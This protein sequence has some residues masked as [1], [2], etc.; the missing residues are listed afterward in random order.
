VRAY[1]SEVSLAWNAAPANQLVSGYRVESSKDGLTWSTVFSNTDQTAVVVGNLVNGNTYQ[2]RVSAVNVAGFGPSATVSAMP[3]GPTSVVDLS[4]TAGDGEVILRWVPP[5]SG[6]EGVAITGIEVKYQL[7]NNAVVVL[8]LLAANA[9]TYTVTGLT[10][11]SLYQFWV[12][13]KTSAGSSTSQTAKATPTNLLPDPVT[14]LAATDVTASGASLSWNAPVQ[15]GLGSITYTVEYRLTTSAT[16]TVATTTLTEAAFALSGLT[17]NKA[18]E[19]KV[20]VMNGV[21][22]S[23]SSFAN[24]TTTA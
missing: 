24:F 9:S 19:V 13:A 15:S 14:G 17:A 12:T 22:A 10:N 21:G 6:G 2:F 4:A 3:V 16:W 11:G 18:Y 5:L 7:G 20:Y 8:P 1:N 23:S